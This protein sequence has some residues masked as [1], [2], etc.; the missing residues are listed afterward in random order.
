LEI[1]YTL[2]DGD[3]SKV[4]ALVVRLE[5]AL[6][7]IRAGEAERQTKRKSL[8]MASQPQCRRGSVADA[9]FAP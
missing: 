5:T 7:V 3:V 9:T 2:L 4:A 8:V 1:C 6:L